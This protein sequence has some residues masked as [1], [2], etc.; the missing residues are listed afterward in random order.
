MKK[1]IRIDKNKNSKPAF[2]LTRIK[3][4]FLP[5]WYYKK[6]MQKIL[7]TPLDETTR[8]RLEYYIKLHHPFSLDNTAKTIETFIK[9][10]R[11]RVYFFDLLSY[12]RY[13]NPKNRFAYLFGD[14][15][16]VPKQPSIV[17]SRPI[18]PNNENS[19]V[20]KLNSVR[21][22]IFVDDTLKFEDKIPKLVWRGKAYAPHRQ[23]FLQKFYNKEC[24]NVGQTNTKGDLNVPWQKETLSLQKQLQYKFILAI[25]G[26]D[27]A[28]N[29]KW[30]MSSNSLV[31]MC[32]PK[33]ETW[34][35]EGL[36]QPNYHYVL[37]KDDYSDLEEK[38]TYYTQHTQEAL[39]IISNAHQHVEQFKDEQKEELLS[40]LVLKN[41]FTLVQ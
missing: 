3:H 22:F 27:V 8:K 34:F 12:L 18:T 26:N 17:K 30:A 20:M 10:E 2:Y 32:Q 13:F 40:V 14:I 9:T 35:M 36:L 23:Q 33:Y 11:K 28:S 1:I 19:V 16:Y 15:T 4:L 5:S 41:Y 29:L 31:F 38:I 21:H 25:E 6:K 39:Q 24:C 37:L 7:Q